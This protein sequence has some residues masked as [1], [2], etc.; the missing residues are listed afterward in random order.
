MTTSNTKFKRF[1]VLFFVLFS[2]QSCSQYAQ[3]ATE[4]KGYTIPVSLKGALQDTCPILLEQ[5]NLWTFDAASFYLSEPK[6]KIAGQWQS[7]EFVAS[8]WQTEQTALVRFNGG[9]DGA[10]NANLI[11][12]TQESAADITGF[13]AT[14]AVPF[15]QN[16]ANP[17]TLAS[18][19]NDAS[20]LWSWQVGHKFI[21]IDM[22]RADSDK[23]WWI[24]LGSVGC[25]SASE[26]RSPSEACTYPNHYQVKVE[27]AQ[28][29][30]EGIV[31]DLTALIEGIDIDAEPGC[32]FQAPTLPSCNKL[33][34]NMAT[35]TWAY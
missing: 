10:G 18:P 22:H 4:N 17:L 19:L 8:A 16:H 6:I 25:T 2:V 28:L 3:E 32:D 27:K 33:T 31:L 7:T 35:G 11:L 26:V 12:N 34:A 20:M 21:R 5:D 9:C 30:N 29:Q 23:Q 14:V 15:E 13:S 24:H 1:G